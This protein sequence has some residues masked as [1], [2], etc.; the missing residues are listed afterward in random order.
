M[1][2]RAQDG[3]EGS[4]YSLKHLVLCKTQRQLSL[5][6][7]L[8]STHPAKRMVEQGSADRDREGAR[9]LLE[10]KQREGQERRSGKEKSAL[11]VKRGAR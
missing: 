7:D 2:D 11:G 4:L 9:P 10:A 3:K 5:F 8:F 6:R 1:H